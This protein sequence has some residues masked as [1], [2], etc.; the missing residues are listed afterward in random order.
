ME[1]RDMSKKK[2]FFNKNHN[3]SKSRTRQSFRDEC[4]INKIMKRV[5]GRMINVS[6]NPKVPIYGDFS[7]I[8]NYTDMLN[9]TIKVRNYFMSLPAMVR[10][11]FENDPQQLID[12]VSDPKNL[13]EARD[14]K[15]LPPDMSGVRYMKKENGQMIDITEEVVNKRGLFKDGVRVGKDGKPVDEG[16]KEVKEE[17]TT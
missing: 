14:L 5:Q 6:T 9:K 8:P 10:A 11:K 16:V 7:D 2:T 1:S 15:L 17:V 4:D 3:Q 13:K 12:F